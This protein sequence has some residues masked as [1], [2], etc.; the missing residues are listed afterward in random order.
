MNHPRPPPDAVYEQAR[1]WLASLNSG[2]VTPAQAKALSQWRAQSPAHEQAWCDTLATW[3]TLQPA[4]KTMLNSE[5]GVQTIAW[6]ASESRKLQRHRRQLI[7]G[8]GV[9]IL[10]GLALALFPPLGLWPSLIEYQADFRT[11]KG[12][13][14]TIQPVQGLTVQMNTA[15]RLSW[16]DQTTLSVELLAGEAEVQTVVAMQIQAGQASIQLNQAKI[17]IR[18]LNDQAVCVS[19]L[20]GYSHVQLGQGYELQAGQ[21]LIYD[22]YGLRSQQAVDIQQVSAWRQ[23]MLS[24]NDVP[25]STVVAEINRY[26]PGRLVLRNQQLANIPVRMLVSA[27]KPDLAVHM[28]TELYQL[29]LINLPGGI[30]LLS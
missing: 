4:L 8:T 27:H 14:R 19:C 11:A 29:E 20:Q 25:L 30:V 3:K 5:D 12:E 10:G 17:N 7:S 21:Q 9:T 26:R 6:A 2:R 28:L 22:Q 23:G 16:K 15:T 1:Q 18:W 13:Q 24:F